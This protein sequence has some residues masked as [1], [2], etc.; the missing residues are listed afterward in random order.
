[1]RYFDSIDRPEDFTSQRFKTITLSDRQVR[2]SKHSY[3]AS[4]MNTICK[5][6]SNGLRCPNCDLQDLVFRSVNYVLLRPTTP[7]I[8]RV[9]ITKK[10]AWQT[11]V[12]LS[13][14]VA[15]NGARITVYMIW[16][17]VAGTSV[18]VMSYVAN[19]PTI[20]IIN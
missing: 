10:I 19:T 11:Y 6:H 13:V 7:F 2:I 1:M 18:L 3:E 14:D 17:F 15:E 20:R 12:V 8:G 4:M 9:K 16:L 5:S